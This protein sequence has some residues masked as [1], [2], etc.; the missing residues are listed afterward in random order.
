MNDVNHAEI[1]RLLCEAV[2]TLIDSIGSGRLGF[3]HA[4]MEYVE[5]FDN[6]FSRA[7]QDYVKAIE[8]CNETQQR[9]S[10]AEK[11]PHRIEEVRREVLHKIAKALNVP[12]VTAFV[13][14]VLESQD[15]HVS[16]VK[17]LQGQSAQLHRALNV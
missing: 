12:E 17:T 5:T 7:L 14:A 15:K 9:L 16:L 4:V 11:D 10:E 8:A 3:D 2:D 6:M 1:I 13:V